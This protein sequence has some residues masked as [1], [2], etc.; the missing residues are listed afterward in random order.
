MLLHMTNVTCGVQ[1]G[2][3][4]LQF[5]I[6]IKTN[7]YFIHQEILVV[8]NFATVIRVTAWFN[9]KN[10]YVCK[11][12]LG[13]FTLRNFCSWQ[14]LALLR[15][16]MSWYFCSLK[17][18][19]IFGSQV[20]KCCGSLTPDFQNLQL[21]TVRPNILRMCV[22]QKAVCFIFCLESEADLKRKW[23]TQRARGQRSI[24]SSQGR[25]GAEPSSQWFFRYAPNLSLL[26]L[27]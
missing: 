24:I 3:F 9:F 6:T 15:A 10:L 8:R 5:Y 27:F 23:G 12:E 18:K 2:M 26:S 14:R 19:W 13:T 1:I 20:Q 7:N 21:T 22:K 17:V 11:T 4:F 25:S 16:E